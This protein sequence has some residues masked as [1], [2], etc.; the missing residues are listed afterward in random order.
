MSSVCSLSKLRKLHLRA[1]LVACRPALEDAL[2][3]AVE[4]DHEVEVV[5]PARVELAG[6]VPRAVIP[7]WRA[8]ARVRSS[9]GSPTCQSPVPA[10][11]MAT[12]S[13]EP[14]LLHEVFEDGFGHG[15]AADVARADEADAK[16]RRLVED[17]VEAHGFIVPQLW[18]ERSPSLRPVAQTSPAQRGA[19][20]SVP[21]LT[22]RP[23]ADA[24]ASRWRE[25]KA[26]RA[27]RTDQPGPPASG[28]A[29]HVRAGEGAAAAPGEDGEWSGAA[30]ILYGLN[31]LKVHTDAVGALEHLRLAVERTQRALDSLDSRG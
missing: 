13:F 26:A 8:D 28:G 25:R 15:R 20:A 12:D 24:L 18:G 27:D 11:M 16:E 17:S 14:G 3:A 19:G 9:D 31:L 5:E 23:A 6:A 30:Q 7:V 4:H 10:E 29:R 22:V 21:F 1:V 2:L